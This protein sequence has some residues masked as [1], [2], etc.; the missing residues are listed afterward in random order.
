M[1]LLKSYEEMYE[2][3]KKSMK[4]YLNHFGS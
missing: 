1:I 3:E 4:D 2:W